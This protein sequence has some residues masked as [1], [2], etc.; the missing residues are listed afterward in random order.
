[1][2]PFEIHDEARAEL[3]AAATYYDDRRR[4]LGNAS[5]SPPIRRFNDCST[6]R[7]LVPW[8]WGMFGDNPW[9]TSP[10]TSC[11]S[12]NRIASGSWP[13]LTTADERRTGAIVFDSFQD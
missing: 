4:G 3:D 8:R 13:P 1:M 7:R 6:I 5:S 9:K 11:L 2:K 10:M 12:M